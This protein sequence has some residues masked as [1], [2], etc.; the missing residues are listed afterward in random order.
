[1]LYLLEQHSKSFKIL[2]AI[3]KINTEGKSFIMKLG[4][5]PTVLQ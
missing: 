2:L 1:M 5:E 3:I 4:P